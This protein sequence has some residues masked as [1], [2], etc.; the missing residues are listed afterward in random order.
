MR[1]PKVSLEVGG[2]KNSAPIDYVIPSTYLVTSPFTGIHVQMIL[3]L[4]SRSAQTRSSTHAVLY[5]TTYV[6]I[7][8]SDKMFHRC[9]LL[10]QDTF[11]NLH[12]P[13]HVG[14]Y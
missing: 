12:P 11:P 3:H 1:K 5:F 2:F 7:A 9:V 13:E 8:Y 14:T 10:S 6:K 4:I